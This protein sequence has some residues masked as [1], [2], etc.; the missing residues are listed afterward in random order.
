MGT[1]LARV[2]A[3]S[4]LDSHCGARRIQRAPGFSCS[5][6][7]DRDAT[8][9]GTAAVF[10]LWPAPSDDEGLCHHRPAGDSRA[11]LS[12]PPQHHPLRRRLRKHR[13]P[14]RG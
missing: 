11:Q 3:D 4:G 10:P 5:G 14:P 9:C 8:S 2:V 7:Q 13:A 6:R 1:T 12:P